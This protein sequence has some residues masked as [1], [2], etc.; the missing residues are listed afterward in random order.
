V[1]PHVGA[2][3]LC[4]APPSREAS[5]AIVMRRLLLSLLLAAVVATCA[6]SPDSHTTVGVRYCHELR[7]ALQAN[8]V[9]PLTVLVK[10][11]LNC[12]AGEVPLVVREGKVV[13]LRGVEEAGVRAAIV[14]EDVLASNSGALITNRGSLLLEGLSLVGQGRWSCVSNFGQL[15]VRNCA[16]SS[17][18]GEGA[19]VAALRSVGPS[20]ASVS[21]T[22]TSFHGW[23]G[24]VS[25]FVSGSGHTVSVVLDDPLEVLAK[26]GSAPSPPHC[27]LGRGAACSGAPCNSCWLE[28][29][30]EQLLGAGAA[31]QGLGVGGDEE[32]GSSLSTAKV[33]ASPPRGYNVTGEEDADDGRVLAFMCIMV[34]ML[35]S[36]LAAVVY[37]QARG[38]GQCTNCE[39]TC[40]RACCCCGLC[41]LCPDLEESGDFSDKAPSGRSAHPWEDTEHGPLM[42]HPLIL[43][44]ERGKG[45]DMKLFSSAPARMRGYSS[46]GG[47]TP[48][49]GS[50]INDP[51]GSIDATIEALRAN[52]VI[53]DPNSPDSSGST[54]PT[55]APAMLVP[56]PG[57]VGVRRPTPKGTPSKRLGKGSAFVPISHK[58]QR[59]VS[60][61]L[62]PAEPQLSAA[63]QG[64]R[65]PPY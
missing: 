2:G 44:V 60:D 24:G 11:S 1:R 33:S 52:R 22:A 20:P 38:E 53:S 37:A 23:G 57:P 40:V 42:R 3:D 34:F 56:R 30:P 59:Q 63:E 43:K 46:M 28:L 16:I 65:S 17:P 15:D 26:A 62:N 54:S 39:R 6:A 32:G 4:D 7:S 29:G 31:Q 27:V 51:L 49:G 9:G 25:F 48:M 14:S 13:T 58:R 64:S 55:G 10:G 35:C 45:M 47:Y 12:G 36:V 8:F 5:P 21:L 18:E 61:E 41:G 50:G 19:L